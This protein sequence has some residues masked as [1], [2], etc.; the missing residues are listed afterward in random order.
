LSRKVSIMKKYI[1]ALLSLILSFNAYSCTSDSNV[2]EN[3]VFFGDEF[4][5]GKDKELFS[6]QKIE[7]KIDSEENK[8]RACGIEGYVN[9]KYGI[10]L[11]G[12]RY[13]LTS[14]DEDFNKIVLEI[15]K[16]KTEKNE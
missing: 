16:I 6:N 9:F 15:L 1:I 13:Y 8:K 7:I 3:A 5:I 2:M 4:I 14:N 12:E 11:N 10:Y